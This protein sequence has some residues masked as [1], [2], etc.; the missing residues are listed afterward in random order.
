MESFCQYRTVWYVAAIVLRLDDG[1]WK[2]I[3]RKSS[4][5]PPPR[6][7]SLPSNKSVVPALSWSK[8]TFKMHAIEHVLCHWVLIYEYDDFYLPSRYFSQFIYDF[9]PKN[10][11]F[12]AFLRGWNN[13]TSGRIGG[14]T[15]PIS[16]T[17][18]RS[19]GANC[20]VTSI[21]Y[22][23]DVTPSDWR[24]RYSDLRK[25]CSEFRSRHSDLRR[26]YSYFRNPHSDLP[27]SDQVRMRNIK[28]ILN[29]S[30]TPTAPLNLLGVKYF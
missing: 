14:F 15:V 13:A 8:T 11:R 22:L 7:S 6:K 5:K 27:W 23:F 19:S 3:Y 10:S 21:R 29:W 30:R 24:K 28:Q 4:N 17:A 1:R 9:K 26:R 12:S 20:G 18:I 2:T 25:R 16:L